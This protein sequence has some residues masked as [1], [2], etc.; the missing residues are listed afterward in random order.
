MRK[1]SCSPKP[2]FPLATRSSSAG[3]PLS[4]SNTSRSSTGAHR[5]RWTCPVIPR[6]APAAR[7]HHPAHQNRLPP[8][9]QQPHRHGQFRRRG[10][11]VRPRFAAPRP[12][13]RRRSLR[14]IPRPFRRA[15]PP[16]AHRRRTQYSLLPHLFQDLRPRRPARRLRLRAETA[17]RPAPARAPALQ[18]QRHRPSRRTAALD[19]QDHL[20]RTRA[21]NAAG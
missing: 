2:L 1:C 18:R 11:S 7:R 5:S 16:P 10:R 8:H 19:D 15:R 20:D 17:H 4:S 6:F 3:T 14:G 12:P 13:L 21:I 9:A